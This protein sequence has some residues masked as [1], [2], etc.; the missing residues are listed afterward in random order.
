M[1]D[2]HQQ[3]LA[4]TVYCDGGADT[5]TMAV[6]LQSVLG[7]SFPENWWAELKDRVCQPSRIASFVPTPSGVKATYCEFQDEDGLRLTRSEN[8]GAISVSVEIFPVNNHF[9]IEVTNS[10]TIPASSALR[11]MAQV[12]GTLKES[13][14]QLA[15]LEIYRADG[16]PGLR[17]NVCHIVR[18]PL[19]LFAHYVTTAAEF[20][21]T[22]P[23][24]VVPF[25]R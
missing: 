11:R 17:L 6:I 15:E 16:L 18:M 8:G 21:E 14:Q 9:Q 25:S 4:H 1:S 23:T 13:G 3:H 20:S 19:G 10:R 7:L 24:F 2:R 22:H 5:K 12:I